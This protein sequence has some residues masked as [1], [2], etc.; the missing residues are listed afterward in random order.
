[1]RHPRSLHVEGAGPAVRHR[2]G[3][4][5][6]LPRHRPDL[7]AHRPRHHQE[8]ALSPRPV[9]PRLHAARRSSALTLPMALLVAVL[10]VCGRL[11]GD[12]E[13]AALKASGVSPLRLFRPFLVVGAARHAAHR[14]AHPRRRARGRAAPSSS[15]SSGSSR[16]APPP[17]SRSAPSAPTF[18]QFVIYVD[19]V[20]AVPGRAC[21]GSLVSD[22]RDP[23][24]PA[25]SW[26]A[27]AGSSPTR[28]N[29]RITLRFLDGSI[30]ETDAGD[31]AA[32]PPHRLQPLRHDPARST[33]PSPRP[34][35]E[36]KPEKRDAAAR[37]S[38]RGARA[39]SA[40]GADR[41]PLLRR[42]AQALRAAGGRAR[43]RARGLSPRHPHATGAAAPSPSASSFVIVVS[44]Y[45]LLHVA[46]G[47]GA[48]GGACPRPSPSGCPTRSSALLGLILL[49]ADDRR[50]CPRPG[51]TCSG[52]CGR[53]VEPR[54]SAA[55][56]PGRVRARAA[57]PAGRL[58]GP[59][60]STFIIDRYLI[61]QY[62]MFLGIGTR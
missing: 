40:Q 45:I 8:R 28:P 59:R 61:R 55:L 52:G 39:S 47:H 21:E 6:V 26:P 48:A 10:L 1:M 30:S 18:S 43:L 16:R 11:A 46:R 5:H 41:H 58:R 60:A 19:E 42:A 49:R 22:E 20:S 56:R 15:S 2:G 31:R 12:L 13:V 35:K 24:R 57:A 4:L 51:S 50:A 9:A 14:L 36:E 34:P 53:A 38:S 29:R 32:L 44:Y 3:R 27:R 33:R 23:E 54:P 62:L 25:S 37:S 17:A 7:P